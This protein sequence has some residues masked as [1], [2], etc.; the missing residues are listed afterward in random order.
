MLTNQQKRQLRQEGHDEP[1]LVSVGKH[2][3]TDT[4]LDSFGV[5]LKA[6]NLVKV[7]LQ[8][9]ATVSTEQV[10]SAFEGEFDCELVHKVGRVLYFYKYH[11]DGRIKV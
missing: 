6:H 1:V 11:E 4:L 2:G 10:I 7:S 9:N 5:S 3:L 8:K